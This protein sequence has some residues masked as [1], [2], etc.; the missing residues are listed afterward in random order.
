MLSLK[1]FAS[2]LTRAQKERKL[3]AT[4]LAQ[5]AGLSDQAVRA[6]LHGEAAPRLTNAMAIADALG[7]ELVLVPKAAAEGLREGQQPQRARTVVSD[8]ERRLGMGVGLE[9]SKAM[10]RGKQ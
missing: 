4:A 1:D 9:P 6:M 8:V 3:S 7:M 2:T 5:R 10:N